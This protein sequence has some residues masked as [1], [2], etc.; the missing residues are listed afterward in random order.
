MSKISR[1]SCELK[2]LPD[3]PFDLNY[4]SCGSYF[5]PLV[6]DGVYQ[7]I[8][9]LCFSSTDT[10]G[11]CRTFDGHNFGILEEK[12]L[13]LHSFSS[14]TLGSYQGYPFTVGGLLP[15]PS[16]VLGCSYLRVRLDDF[17]QLKV[18]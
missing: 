4:A 9:L 7:N 8:A 14:R 2:R 12:P 11:T 1:Q 3:L 15:Y 17:N 18:H 10:I 16:T 5:M 6:D 13:M